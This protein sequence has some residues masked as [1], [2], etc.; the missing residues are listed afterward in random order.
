MQRYPYGQVI[1]AF[2]AIYWTAGGLATYLILKTP[3]IG[4]KKRKKWPIAVVVLVFLAIWMVI[5]RTY[6][7]GV[8]ADLGVAG[9]LQAWIRHKITFRI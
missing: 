3:P 8:Y 6:A 2:F 9:F 1:L 7:P 4:R 5:D